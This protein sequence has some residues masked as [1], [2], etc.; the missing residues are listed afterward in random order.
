MRVIN[1]QHLILEGNGAAIYIMGGDTVIAE[2]QAQ[3]VTRFRYQ[4]LTKDRIRDFAFQHRCAFQTRYFT[5]G[6]QLFDRTAGVDGSAMV[7]D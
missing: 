7:G 3:G 6:N 1:R 5:I 2:H 4:G